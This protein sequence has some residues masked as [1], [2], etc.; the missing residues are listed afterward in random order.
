[1]R[2]SPSVERSTVLR[3]TSGSI[4]REMEQLIQQAHALLSWG[5]S[6][7][8]D[9]NLT[10]WRDAR[11]RWSSRSA[12]TL[13]AHFAPEAVREFARANDEPSVPREGPVENE[14]RTLRNAIELLRSLTSTLRG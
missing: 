7:A 10:C 9:A 13:T 14:L 8:E 3:D 4:T 1:M 5:Q 2:S 12:R 6:I 11:H